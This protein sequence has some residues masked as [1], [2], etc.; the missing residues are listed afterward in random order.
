VFGGLVADYASG[1]KKIGVFV[2]LGACSDNGMSARA[3]MIS[4]GTNF[5]LCLCK[6]INLEK[7]Y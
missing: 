3:N 1:F 6:K 7:K 4:S 2:M 5:Y